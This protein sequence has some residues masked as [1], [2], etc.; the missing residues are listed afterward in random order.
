MLLSRGPKQKRTRPSDPHP[1]A[2][3]PEAYQLALAVLPHIRH[4]V[5]EDSRRVDRFTAVALLG[6]RKGEPIAW[7][8]DRSWRASSLMLPIG[9]TRKTVFMRFHL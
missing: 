3:L 6:I 8:K 2:A 5:P 7:A 9:C 1:A 4:D